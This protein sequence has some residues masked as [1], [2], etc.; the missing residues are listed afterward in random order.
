MRKPDIDHGPAGRTPASISQSIS[1]AIWTSISTE[2]GSLD[3]PLSIPNGSTSASGLGPPKA[4]YR[5]GYAALPLVGSTDERE[6]VIVAG[7]K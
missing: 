7:S 4:R 6:L 5:L 3:S 2:W 1:N